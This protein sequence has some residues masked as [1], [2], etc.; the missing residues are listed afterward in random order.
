MYIIIAPPLQLC[1]SHEDHQLTIMVKNKKTCIRSHQRGQKEL[2]LIQSLFIRKLSL[3]E[4]SDGS[5]K[6]STCKE[7]CICSDW[8]SKGT[9]SFFL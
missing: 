5:M 6:Y 1:G 4:P 9:K 7:V 3:F 2:E 8:S